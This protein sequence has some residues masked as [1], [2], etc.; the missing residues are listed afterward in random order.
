MNNESDNYLQDQIDRA[1]EIAD[2]L[3]ELRKLR[4]DE[5]S[6]LDKHDIDHDT[7]GNQSEASFW[8]NE[9]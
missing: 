5:Y 9:D 2:A 1:R 7:Y 8:G 3:K 4:M 6:D